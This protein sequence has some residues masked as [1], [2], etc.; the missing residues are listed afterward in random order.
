M[1][2]SELLA[3]AAG[4]D[5]NFDLDFAEKMVEKFRLDK[6]KKYNSLS[7]G[8]KT[9]VTTIISLASNDEIILLDEPVLGFD[10]VMRRQFY[11]LLSESYERHPR[12]IVISTHL[13]DEIADVAGQIIAIDSGKLLFYEDINDVLEKSYKVTGISDT[14]SLAVKDVNVISREKIGKFTSAYIS[15]KRIPSVDGIEIENVSLQDLF[16]KMVEVTQ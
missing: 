15:D 10:A 2:I 7:F 8:M 14:V 13:I 1:R 9:M 16:I 12:I 11:D 4:V 6:R 5:E 3:L